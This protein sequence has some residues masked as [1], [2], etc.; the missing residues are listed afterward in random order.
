MAVPWLVIAVLG[1]AV[2][3]VSCQPDQT[4][5]ANPPHL[6]TEGMLLCVIK[7]YNKLGYFTITS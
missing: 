6:P 2:N 4:A 3:E 1:I 5:F 7:V